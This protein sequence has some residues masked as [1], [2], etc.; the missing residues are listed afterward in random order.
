[1]AAATA[2]AVET[3][4]AVVVTAAAAATV[5]VATAV[6]TEAVI[7]INDTTLFKNPFY[8]KGFFYLPF[9]L[10]NNAKQ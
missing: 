9:N 3:V 5:A 6:T 8:T 4:A 1:V 10:K 7:N 2:A